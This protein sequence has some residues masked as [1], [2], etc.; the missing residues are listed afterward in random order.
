VKRTKV[1][2]HRSKPLSAQRKAAQK[3]DDIELYFKKFD[4]RYQELE[5][6]LENLYNFDETG[7][8]IG[9]LTGQIVFTQTDRQVYILD[10]DNYELVTSIESISAI[11]KTTNLMIIM[12]G[13]QI[14]EKHFPKGLND[15]I[16]IVVSESGY[17]NDILS[18][19][20]LKHFNVQTQPLNSE[21]RMLVIDGYGL[22]LTIEFVDYCY[23][24]NVKIF[25]FLLPLHSTHILQ[26]LDI[27]VFQSFKHYY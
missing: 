7:F 25:M 1:L 22:H 18:F 5:M 13:Q 4:T 26:L 12:P 10:L 23:Y 3:R 8:R 19:E 2:Q 15:G 9:C 27:G 6:K 16:R 14:K 20:W 21:W 11:G 17:T 24:L